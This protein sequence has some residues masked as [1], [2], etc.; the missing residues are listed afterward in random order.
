MKNTFKKFFDLCSILIVISMVFFVYKIAES[1]RLKKKFESTNLNA[2][3]SV[4]KSSWGNPD[5]ELYYDG[6][7][8]L[9]YSDF[10]FGDTYI[11][12]FDKDKNILVGKFIDD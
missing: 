9:K 10:L 11:F 6:N 8:I 5:S 12:V 7:K 4:I 2:T 3:L 1:N